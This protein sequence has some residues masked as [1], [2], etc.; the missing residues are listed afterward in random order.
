MTNRAVEIRIRANNA[1][2]VAAIRDTVRALDGAKVSGVR[3]LD[4]VRRA[5]SGGSDAFRE[6]RNQ[7][8]GLASIGAGIA[9][10][11]SI[12]QQADAAQQLQGRLKLVTDGASDLANVNELLF[13]SSQRTGTAFS[14]NADLYIRLATAGGELGASQ[15]QLIRFSEGVGNALTLSGA[16]A[17]SASGALIQLSQALGGGIVRAEEFN[18]ILEGAPVIIQTVAR[19]LDAAGGSVSKLRKLVNDGKVSSADFFA[20][21]ERG[22]AGLASQVAELPRTVGRATTE[23][24]NEYQRLIAGTDLSP[25][26]DSIDEL[27]R[28]ISDPAVQDGIKAIASGLITFV[29]YGARAAAAIG[30]VSKAVGEGAGA[31]TQFAAGVQ[32]GETPLLRLVA[33][34]AAFSNPATASFAIKYIAGLRD[35]QNAT[36]E[37]ASGIES[38]ASRDVFGKLFQPFNDQLKNI[39]QGLP[40][41]TSV[42]ATVAPQFR[43]VGDAAKSATP[44]ITGL[45]KATKSATQSVIEQIAELKRVNTLIAAGTAPEEAATRARLEGDK[46]RADVID[47]LIQQQA[48][49]KA[50]TDALDAE[51]AA[52]EELNQ[53]L[54]EAQDLR[55]TA[56]LDLDDAERR[57]ELI[58]AGATEQAAANQV[59]R[60]AIELSI[61]QAEDAGNATKADEQRARQRIAEVDDEVQAIIEGRERETKA[62]EAAAEQ[63]ARAYERAAGRIEESSRAVFRAALGG[64]EDFSD[65]LKSSFND[66]LAELAYQAA[67]NA[68]I[69]PIVQRVFGPTDGAGIAQALGSSGQDAGLGG[70]DFSSLGS[71]FGQSAAS[72]LLDAAY[73]IGDL[74][75]SETAYAFADALGT[76]STFANVSAA[77]SALGAAGAGYGIGSTVGGF[78]E[79]KGVFGGSTGN[80]VGAGAATGAAIGSVVPGVGTVVGG[81]V[82]GAA[83]LLASGLIGNWKLKSQEVAIAFVDGLLDA[84]FT[85]VDKKKRIGPDK[86]RTT[87]DEVTALDAQLSAL[88]ADVAKGASEVGLALGS[89]GGALNVSIKGLSEQEAQVAITDAV[90]QKL[91]PTLSEYRQ[92]E[93]ALLTTYQRIVG[94]TLTLRAAIEDLG[95]QMSLLGQTLS[96]ET[97]QA[98]VVA[99]GGLDVLAGNLSTFYREF[100]SEQEQLQNLTRNL[101]E[102]AAE[103]GF[104]LPD[105]REGFR[106]LVTGLDLTTEAGQRAF[107]GLTSLAGAADQL[108]DAAEAALQEQARFLAQ[109]Q[110]DA[111]A[112]QNAALAE[113]LKPAVDAAVLATRLAT[114][115]TE[116]LAAQ[117]ELGQLAAIGGPDTRA[118]LLA[119]GDGLGLAPGPIGRD[120][121]FSRAN[122]ALGEFRDGLLAN[123]TQTVGLEKG[124][125]SLNGALDQFVR[126][127]DARPDSARALSARQQLLD[128][129]AFGGF[130]F[131]KPVLQAQITVDQIG[132]FATRV[133][134][135]GADVERLT[136]AYD[137]QDAK[138]LALT[139]E[140][141]AATADYK[142]NAQAFGDSAAVTSAA[143]DRL[144]AATAAFEKGITQQSNSILRAAQQQQKAQ[145]LAFV[146]DLFGDIKAQANI[147]R[148]ALAQ[149]DPVLAQVNE[150]VGHLESIAFAFNSAAE[151]FDN[152]ARLVTRRR[153]ASIDPALV[154]KGSFIADLA[155]R[156]A[157]FVNTGGAA[158]TQNLVA[159]TL[160]LTGEDAKALAA[161]V[162]GVKVADAKSFEDS[163]TLLSDAFA[164]GSITA[165]QFSQLFGIAEKEFKGLIDSSVGF[166]EALSKA[167]DQLAQYRIGLESSAAAQVLPEAA[168]AAL[169]DQFSVLATAAAGGNQDALA[170][171]T[172]VADQLLASSKDVFASGAGFQ[173]DLTFVKGTLD[174]LIAG[175]G[176]P[177]VL[178]DVSRQQLS[179]LTSINGS[180]RE[181]IAAV[182]ANK[183]VDNS[184]LLKAAIQTSQA[185]FNMLG[186]GQKDGNNAL[187]QVQSNQ[188]LEM[189]RPTRK[190]RGVP[191]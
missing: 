70:F 164:E 158:A 112:A 39:A 184:A 167:A 61:Q 58:R 106:A 66:L 157:G 186:K 153:E 110:Q 125:A 46:V 17:Q 103:L 188:R 174:D 143:Y 144:I 142:A 191:A 25:V 109:A 36:N 65:Q 73:D 96:I 138:V 151:A 24:Q 119:S 48:L 168:R 72:A 64:F 18:S 49:N 51:R 141:N 105:T 76:P 117:R 88:Y 43:V 135:S 4:A 187:D 97:A 185:G 90:L 190:R 178:S 181:L 127:V 77:F 78:L 173:D 134:R 75:G 100:Y 9:L 83:G 152:G 52:Q 180:L 55:N 137:I 115:A 8:L 45:D 114:T 148:A 102:S 27:K 162:Q 121:A 35:A 179:A 47:K 21:F 175:A 41:A 165:D 131:Q 31:F 116:Y 171:I 26:V 161:L 30:S 32:S 95:G 57:L 166:G 126:G 37:F 84:T 28:T 71:N 56:L 156:A 5:A 113:T 15:Q 13:A 132:A 53:A 79:N 118:A 146:G 68:I 101:T 150:T 145:A 149:T 11:K 50:Q 120:A 108:Y 122:A 86:T 130:D 104:V 6:L 74:T 12:I 183:P 107:A 123:I 170:S 155:S 129:N 159:N 99:A 140:L 29:E 91:V 163:F 160:G 82:G 89:L 177:A 59:Q 20:A 23:L 124:L 44:A 54:R 139:Q 94:Q 87:V 40:A 189:N 69:I 92:G 172:G 176:G 93:E 16:T 22:Q 14:A 42:L 33:V 10:A 80:Y 67:K 63:Q 128:S 85:Q 111:V 133:Q 34:S 147:V 182:Q 2:A 98:L 169:L 1:Q 38:A 19:N 7:A 62:A 60:E 3:N 81:V 154:A 136:A